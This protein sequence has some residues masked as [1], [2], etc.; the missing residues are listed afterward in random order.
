MVGRLR[1]DNGDLVT[2]VGNVFELQCGEQ[3]EVE[4]KWIVNKTYG[5]Q[6]EISSVEA[7]TPITTKG[8][9]SYL[10]SGM[11]KGIGAAMA[12]RIVETFWKR[13]DRSPG[14]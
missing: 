6:F 4:G 11:I 2:I 9:E 14:Q 8:I 5:R 10:G 1:L 7:Y 13:Y 3:L 12:S